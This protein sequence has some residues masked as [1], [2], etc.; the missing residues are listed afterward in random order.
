M[1]SSNIRFVFMR[2]IFDEFVS[3]HQPKMVFKFVEYSIH[4]HASN[5]RQRYF[6]H[7]LK[8]VSKFVEYSMTGIFDEF[9]AHFQFLETVEYSVILSSTIRSVEYS[10]VLKTSFFPSLSP[11]DES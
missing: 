1:N 3:F 9:G 11:N 2:R 6:F 8:M 10:K 7:Q 4:F 5:I